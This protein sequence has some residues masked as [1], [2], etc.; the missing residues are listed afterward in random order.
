MFK[1]FRTISRHRVLPYSL[2]VLLSVKINHHF[3]ARITLQTDDTL[4]PN[5]KIKQNI[6]KYELARSQD[7]LEAEFKAVFKYTFYYYIHS[8]P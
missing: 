3:N 7:I 2:A 5:R 1:I 4:P 6:V 8:S